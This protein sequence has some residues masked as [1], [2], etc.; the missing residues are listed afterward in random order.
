MTITFTRDIAV[1]GLSGSVSYSAK[2]VDGSLKGTG[3]V[4]LGD[5]V[6]GGGGP[7][8]FTATRAK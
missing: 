8:P 2:L 4:K 1:Q 7:T 3:D 6:P 5:A